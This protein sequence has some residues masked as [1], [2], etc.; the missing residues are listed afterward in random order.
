L[1]H[2]RVRC[3][4]GVLL[5]SLCLPRPS[6]RGCCRLESRPGSARSSS[7][8]G[9]VGQAAGAT[10]GSATVRFGRT[11][12]LATGS[13][14]SA[15][16][17]RCRIDRAPVVSVRP[18]LRAVFSWCDDGALL[19]YARPV[20]AESAGKFTAVVATFQVAPRQ[21]PTLLPTTGAG[22]RGPV[23]HAGA[24]DGVDTAAGVRSSRAAKEHTRATTV[25]THERVAVL[26]AGTLSEPAG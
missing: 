15:I 6:A 8:G 22:S 3:S 4:T 17:K 11:V 14:A 23:H 7:S 25:T 1:I 19:S 20:Q 12:R 10:A 26:A 24:V 9:A 16:S 5:A 2:I 13:S 21:A 18:R